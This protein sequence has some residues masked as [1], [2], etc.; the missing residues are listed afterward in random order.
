M[1]GAG[2]PKPQCHGGRHTAL[3]VWA[4]V[5]RASGLTCAVSSHIGVAH[6]TGPPSVVFRAGRLLEQCGAIQACVDEAEQLVE[7][8]WNA[9]APLFK[10]SLSKVMLRAFG[11]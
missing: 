9:A 4:A 8:S 2:Y 7:T 1:P 11:W 3:E 5:S 6:R 10:P